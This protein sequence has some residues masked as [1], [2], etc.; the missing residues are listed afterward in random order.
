MCMSAIPHVHGDGHAHTHAAPDEVEGLTR[1]R[2]FKMSAVAAAGAAI[3]ATGVAPAAVA[4]DRTRRNVADLTHQL[5]IDFPGFFGGP[6]SISVRTVFD[7]ETAGFLAKEWTFYE[8][9]GTHIDTPGHFSPGAALVDELDVA[10]LVAPLVVIDITAKAN[11]N[12]NAV[13]DVSDIS[14]WER[15]HGRIPNGSLVTARSG[16]DAKVRDGDVFRG[17]PGYPDINFPGFGWPAAEFL[18]DRRNV[19]GIGVDTLS[20]DPGNSQDFAVHVN[21]LGSG[22]Y[23]IE[24]LANLGGVPPRGATAFV[25]AIP[26]EGGTGGP[27]RVIAT[28]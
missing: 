12:P 7:F 6:P 5:F 22:H 26:Y 18:A 25:G 13:V 23:G 10:T 3:A 11:A 15:E 27:V 8:H 16:W 20:L 21:F 17:G 28:W 9:I 2:F 24:A 1:R 14:A 19:V 4:Q